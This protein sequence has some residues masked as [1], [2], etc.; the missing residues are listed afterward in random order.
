MWKNLSHNSSESNLFLLVNFHICAKAMST[1]GSYAL[2]QSINMS[3]S[4][5]PT[6]P[7]TDTVSS[8]SLYQGQTKNFH[9]MIF[10]LKIDSKLSLKGKRKKIQCNV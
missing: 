1:Q 10:F 5:L 7:K 3:S 2:L 8:L 9:L 6:I 4:G